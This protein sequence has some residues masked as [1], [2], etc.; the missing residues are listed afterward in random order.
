[1]RFARFALVMLC[2]CLPQVGPRVVDGGVDAGPVPDGGCAS[3]LACDSGVCAAG[4]CVAPEDPCGAF[5]GCTTFT[6]LTDAAADRRIVFPRNG[7]RYQPQCARVRFGQSVTFEGDFTEHGL[8][9]AC[10]PVASGLSASSG[11]RFTLTFDRALGV[12]GYHCTKHGEATGTG[13]AGAIDVVR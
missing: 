6:D 7:D 13:M 3:A 5:A 10:G 9:S 2:G 12:F 4:R 8:A 11:T 1:M